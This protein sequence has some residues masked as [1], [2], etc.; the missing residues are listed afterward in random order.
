MPRNNFRRLEIATTWDAR[1]AL[2]AVVAERVFETIGPLSNLFSKD[3]V[4]IWQN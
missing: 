4:V 2:F 1:F 3:V